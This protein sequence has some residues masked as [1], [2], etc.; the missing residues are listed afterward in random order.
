[1]FIMLGFMFNATTSLAQ[2]FIVPQYN[3]TLTLPNETGFFLV[4][5]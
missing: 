1:M 5:E 3:D 2:V 4:N